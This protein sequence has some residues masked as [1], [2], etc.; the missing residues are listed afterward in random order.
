MRSSAQV[1][2]TEIVMDDG[3]GGAGAAIT[4]DENTLAP[5]AMTKPAA[6]AS[7]VFR[8]LETR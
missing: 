8:R 7:A 5:A 3:A 2:E 1:P 4:P 6:T